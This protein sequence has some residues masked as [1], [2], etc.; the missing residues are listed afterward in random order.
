MLRMCL[1]A[2]TVSSYSFKGYSNT[3]SFHTQV[4]LSF[5]L[6]KGEGRGWD[7]A[8]K[9]SLVTMKGHLMF[10]SCFCAFEVFRAVQNCEQ[11]DYKLDCSLIYWKSVKV[12]LCYD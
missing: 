8:I 7:N 11:F 6:L 2:C 5:E 10:R 4:R 1:K 3:A 9:L 12:Q